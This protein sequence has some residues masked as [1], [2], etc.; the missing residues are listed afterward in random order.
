MYE[1]SDQ[2]KIK[3]HS[4]KVYLLKKSLILYPCLSHLK[5]EK[6]IQLG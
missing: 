4:L 1:P 6:S 5:V 3:I 2:C